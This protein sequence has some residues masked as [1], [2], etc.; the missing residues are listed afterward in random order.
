MSKDLELLK[1]EKDVW[2]KVYVDISYG[3][4]NVAPFLNENTLKVRKYYGKVD[5]LKR[6][7]TF[8][9]SSEAECKKNASSFLGRFKENNSIS[10]ISTYKNDNIGDFNQLKNCSKCVC[11]NCPKDC[12]FNSCRGCRENSFIKKCDHE[13]INM[14]VHDNFI[15]NL[16]NNST[17]NPSSYKVLATLQDCEFQRQYIIIENIIDKEDK[18]V[19]YYYPGIS[20]D[21]YGEISDAGE[22]DFIVETFGV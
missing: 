15:L 8:L 2:G 11:L 13:K 18:F 6:Y 14:T 12:N 17:G 7:I 21:D 20:E 22:F 5:V 19:L 16:T 10:L 3:I 9:E 4:D 1:S